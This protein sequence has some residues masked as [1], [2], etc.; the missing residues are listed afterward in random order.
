L[1]AHKEKYGHLFAIDERTGETLKDPHGFELPL[2]IP[3]VEK[4]RVE[5]VLKQV[6]ALNTLMA[7]EGPNTSSSDRKGPIDM[8][9]YAYLFR[10]SDEKTGTD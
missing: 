9:A 1:N 7:E 2:E 6:E 10:S 5:L 4:T 3:T 8:S